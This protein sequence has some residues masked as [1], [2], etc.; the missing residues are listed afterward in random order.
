MMDNSQEVAPMSK[1]Q[2]HVRKKY[3]DQLKHKD[4]IHFGT[5]ENARGPIEV[6]FRQLDFNP[7]VFRSS[8][9]I[10][11][12]VEDFTDTAQEYA[13]DH[14]GVSMAATIPWVIKTA[15]RRRFKAQ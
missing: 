15:L 11:S 14:L 9:E 13:V 2:G 10:S 7:L 5:T 3:I 4:Q 1:F 6:I 8:T 12:N